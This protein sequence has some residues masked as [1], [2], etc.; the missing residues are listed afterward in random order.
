MLPRPSST[1]LGASPTPSKLPRPTLTPLGADGALSKVPRPPSKPLEVTSVDLRAPEVQSH[2]PISD[3]VPVETPALG[4]P[5]DLMTALQTMLKKSPM[6]LMTAL[7]TMLK[8]SAHD[9]LVR[10]PRGGQVYREACC[11]ALRACGIL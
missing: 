2:L 5:M 3:E 7:Q 4:E 9:R 11:T 1:P 10:G 8:K 6:D